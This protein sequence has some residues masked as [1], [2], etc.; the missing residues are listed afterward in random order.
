VGHRAARPW[1]PAEEAEGYNKRLYASQGYLTHTLKAYAANPVWT[2]DPKRAAFRDATERSLTYASAGHWPP[3]LLRRSGSSLS[4]KEG[5]PPLGLFPSHEYG[6]IVLPLEYGD[7]LIL[8]TDGLTEALNSKGQEFGEV[9]LTA[10]GSQNIRLSAAQMLAM[11][12]REVNRHCGGC[13]QDDLT[14]VVVAVR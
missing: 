13:F 12:K 4:L 8:Y 11:L 14:L 10:I 7:Q 6:N 2:E 3:V 9:N 1:R 5:G